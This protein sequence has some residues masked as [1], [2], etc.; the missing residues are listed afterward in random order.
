ME[1]R[2]N[3]GPE[4]PSHTKVLSKDSPAQVLGHKPELDTMSAE[5]S[6]IW[7][8]YVNQYSDGIV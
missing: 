2:N 6:P 4:T 3:K 5:I 1:R 7:N 8:K